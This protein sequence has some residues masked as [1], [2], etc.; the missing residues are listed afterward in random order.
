MAASSSKDPSS[1]I[2]KKTATNKALFIVIHVSQVE[3][4]AVKGPATSP[5]KVYADKF[6]VQMEDESSK[7][8][9]GFRIPCKEI[10]SLDVC[11]SVDIFIQ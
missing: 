2:K 11:F 8:E 7:K 4:G 10:S 6:I 1:S 5:V 3:L 9:I